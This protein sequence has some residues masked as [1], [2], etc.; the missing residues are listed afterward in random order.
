MSIPFTLIAGPCVLESPELVFDMAAE[1]K[2][3][4]ERLGI[5]LL[6]KTSFDKANRS[7]GGSFRGP[8]MEQGLDRT[9]LANEVAL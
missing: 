5:R 7:S 3:I 8:G 6:F 4:S 1:L 9:D 2:A